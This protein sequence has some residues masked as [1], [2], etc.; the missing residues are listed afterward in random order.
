MY[1]RAG[2]VL[3]KPLQR[4]TVVP[5][6]SFIQRITRGWSEKSNIICFYRTTLTT[7]RRFRC[8]KMI[9]TR[10]FRPSEKLKPRKD[11]ANWKICT[12]I[13]KKYFYLELFC[14]FIEFPGT[15]PETIGRGKLPK[16][17]GEFA[18]RN[19]KPR[20]RVLNFTLSGCC[21][22]D[23]L[24]I[25]VDVKISTKCEIELWTPLPGNK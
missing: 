23:C 10:G 22:S 21:R 12:T 16:F 1:Y 8:L 17:K 11:P 14:L 25:T 6:R 18:S 20:S 9:W 5:P 15:G 24:V 4:L 13:G 2:C 19:C 7:R 3:Q